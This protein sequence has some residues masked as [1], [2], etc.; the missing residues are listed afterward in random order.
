MYR[1]RTSNEVLK[2]AIPPQNIEN[3]PVA[4]LPVDIFENKKKHIFYFRYFKEIATVN[5]INYA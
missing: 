3:P 2:Q 5:V 1:I 4:L